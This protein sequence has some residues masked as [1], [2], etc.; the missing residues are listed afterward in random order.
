MY[1]VE[2]RVLEARAPEINFND[3]EISMYLDGLLE[4]YEGLI[5]TDETVKDCKATVTELNKMIKSVDAFRLKYKKEYSEPIAAFEMK[6][7]TLIAQIEGV[8]TPLK[9]QADNFEIKRRTDRRVEV[10]GYIKE[11]LDIV[12]LEAKWAN[13]VEC[14]EE[15]LNVSLS[16]SKCKQAIMAEIQKLES[17][18]KSYYDKME[19]VK[20]K[21]ELYSM[22]FGLEVA[23]IPENF[24][25]LLDNYDGPA[26]DAKIYEIAEKTKANE[27]AAFERIKAQ[28]EEK[29]KIEA[30]QE[31]LKAQQEAQQEV[32]KAQLE[33]KQET[34][35]QLADIAAVVESVQEFIPLVAEPEVKRHTVTLQ[36][37]AT[38]QQMDA[39]KA[40]MDASGITYE[41][42]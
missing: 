3:K 15:W 30:Q 20:T 25:H 6:C 13:Q 2:L 26:I 41:R 4:Q 27:Q 24:Y 40:Y 32:L 36:I 35:K 12:R 11:A 38:K 1:A 33:A 22:K 7:K 8:Q 14:R 29:A 28:A 18:Q 19:V 31:I 42:I 5:F 10:E 39:L 34:E 17:E 37:N 16:N 21:S 9:E 23:L